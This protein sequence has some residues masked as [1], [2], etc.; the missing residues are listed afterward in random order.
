MDFEEIDKMGYLDGD[1]PS[2]PLR[3]LAAMA[4]LLASQFPL[5]SREFRSWIALSGRCEHAARH[6][7]KNAREIHGFEGDD[8]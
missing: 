3:E 2:G 5:D 6:A 4:R 7:D 8:T 1:T